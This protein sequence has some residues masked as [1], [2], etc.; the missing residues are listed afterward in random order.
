MNKLH[1]NPFL[2]RPDHPSYNRRA[3]HHDYH[4]PAKYLITTLKNP[5]IPAFAKIEGNPYVAYGDDAPHTRLTITGNFIIE[6]M[7]IWLRKYSQIDVSE[8]VVMPDHIHL[9]LHVKSY[10][11]NG[12]SLAMAGFKGIVSRLRHDALPDC[13]RSATM[14]SV[15]EKGFNDKIAYS[16]EQ[17]ERQRSYVRDN[18]RRFLIKNLY[19]D[20]MYRRWKV[21][22][23]DRE[24]V[25]RGNILL[26]K[27]PMLFVVKHH[28]R[29]SEV[30]SDVYQKTCRLRIENGEVP[31]SPF[32]HPKE[33]ELRDYAIDDGGCYI[34][35]CENGFDKRQSASGVEFDMLSS[36]RLLL[37][38]P[39]EHDTQKKDMK[40]EY[41]Q[42][43]NALAAH[44]VEM[45]NKG[46][47]GIICS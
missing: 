35:I 14:V 27:E 4:R 29:W 11:P 45:H 21:K 32:I 13:F 43:L 15:F 34:R 28:R 2:R 47:S 30:E 22:L 31:V 46:L 7:K 16:N 18:P 8:F 33:K 3:L 17:W 5:A 1:N 24:F 40:Y 20:F 42:M 37:I 19:P 25:A 6:A 38:A 44:L 41:A 9:C 36:G 39:V 10:L 12:L 26:L 23:G